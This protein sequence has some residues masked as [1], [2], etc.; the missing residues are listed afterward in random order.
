M[1]ILEVIG[2]IF[3][4]LLGAIAPMFAPVLSPVALAWFVH[5]LLLAGVSVGLYYV[6]MYTGIKDKIRGPD[7]IRPYWLVILFALAYGLA[8]ATM[9]LSGLLAPR[10]TTAIYPDLDEAWDSIKSSLEKA[11]IGLADTPVLLVLGELPSGYDALFRALPQGLSVNGGSPGG[12][13]LRAYANRDAIY[14]TLEGAT[15]LGIQETGEILLAPAPTDSNAGG[16]ASIGAGAS[17]GIGKSVGMSMG[18]SVGGMGG[19]L[20]QIQKII[21]QARQQGRPLTD[22]EKEQIRELSGTPAAG[23]PTRGA[24]SSGSVLQ[25]PQIV[26]ETADRL[27]HVCNLVAAARWPLCPINGAILTIPISATDRDDAAQQ[28]GLVARQDLAVIEEVFQLQFPVF[29]LVGEA[30][31]LPGGGLFFERFAVDK[32]NQRLG[33]SFPL[34]P[35]IAPDELPDAIEENVGWIFGNLLSYWSIR[36]TR[37]DGANVS[38]DTRDNGQLVRFRSELLKRAPHL[39]RLVSRAMTAGDRAPVFGGCYIS[40]VLKSAPDHAKFARDF[41]KKVQDSQGFVAWT[42]D[43]LVRDAGYRSRTMQ[44][45]VLLAVV[46]VAVL[47][48]AGWTIFGAGHKPGA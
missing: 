18:G 9:W 47:G 44:G 22:A 17:I 45:Y 40:A 31:T 24:S 13:P 28:W 29:A 23:A 43:A 10:Q 5:L 26:A 7:F 11:G 32:G 35:Q 33:K 39:A 19:T 4:W 8:W 25:N 37:I 36:L 20:Q 34:N 21:Q 41:F 14:L 46:L 3:R 42:D 27:A 2:A 12:S 48:L 6:Q 16:M 30:E 15:L 1:K 38:T